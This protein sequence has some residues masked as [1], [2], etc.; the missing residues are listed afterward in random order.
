M[1]NT[2]IPFVVLTV[3]LVASSCS[4]TGSKKIANPFGEEPSCKTVSS[5]KTT[6]G[7]KPPCRMPDPS[8]DDPAPWDGW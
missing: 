2:L 4:T 1:T 6:K 5:E 7:N 3:V 8:A